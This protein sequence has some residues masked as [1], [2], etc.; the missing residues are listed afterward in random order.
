MTGDRQVV[1]QVTLV[2]HVSYF[3]GQLSDPTFLPDSVSDEKVAGPQSHPAHVEQI[4]S[5]NT[6]GNTGGRQAVQMVFDTTGAS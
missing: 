5:E 3:H 6:R 4:L 2:L 1:S